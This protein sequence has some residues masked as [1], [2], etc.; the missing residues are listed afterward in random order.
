MKKKLLGCKISSAIKLEAKK[1]EG[2]PVAHA[3]FSSRVF[4]LYFSK[5]RAH[6]VFLSP[7]I[8][9]VFLFVKSK[10]LKQNNLTPYIILAVVVF[11]SLVIYIN[12]DDYHWW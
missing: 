2:D 7:D 5:R 8:L 4:P 9:L 10:R 6:F 11:I 1:M 12:N 3:P